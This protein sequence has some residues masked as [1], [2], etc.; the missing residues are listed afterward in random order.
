MA[1]KRDFVA[2]ADGGEPRADRLMV[3]Y[4]LGVHTLGY[5]FNLSGHLEFPLLDH[6]EVADDVNRRV[7]SYEGE[8]VQFLVLEESVGNLD[9]ALFPEM[10]ARKV[11]S[12]GDPVPG[13]LQIQDVKSLE[14][15]VRRYVVEHCPVLQRANYQLFVTVCHISDIFHISQKLTKSRRDY[16]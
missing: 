14:D 10:S 1:E 5:A 4:A 15:P 8:L 6:L 11:D 16:L 7:R 13:V 2:P 9:Y 3:G 12:D